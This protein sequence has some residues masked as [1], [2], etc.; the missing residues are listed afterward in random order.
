MKFDRAFTSAVDFEH[1]GCAIAIEGHFRVRNIVG[2]N[3]IV[4]EAE[5]YR[6]ME[7]RG[8]SRGRGRIIW[9]VEPHQLGAPRNFNGNWTKIRQERIFLTKRHEVGLTTVENTSREV[10]WIARVGNQYDIT[11]IDHGDREIRDSL[12]GADQRAG[13]FLRVEDYAEPRLVP[14]TGSLAKAVETLIIRITMI[15]RQL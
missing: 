1:T 7:E 6:A 13:F 8:I 3:Y 12:L 4:I 2:E 5:F 14:A 10:H 9:I 15:E 11:G